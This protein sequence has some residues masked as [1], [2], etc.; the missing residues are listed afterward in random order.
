MKDPGFGWSRVTQI[1]GDK[2]ILWAGWERSVFVAFVTI[3]AILCD[4]I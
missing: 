3:F 1:L 4:E 2:L